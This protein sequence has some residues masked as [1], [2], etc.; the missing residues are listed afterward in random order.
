MAPGRKQCFNLEGSPIRMPT[1]N[2]MP[3][4]SGGELAI[5]LSGGGARAAYQVGLLRC[6]A[7]HWPD[8]R[9]P[10]ITGVSAGAINAGYLA[11]CTEGFTQKVDG[12]SELWCSLTMEQVFRTDSFSLIGNGLRL[13]SMLLSGGAVTRQRPHS[14]VDTAP[15]RS[16]LERALNSEKGRLPGI[17]K[18]L[19]RGDLKAVAITTSSYSTGQ[20]IT[21][22]QGRGIALWDRAHRRAALRNLEVSHIM[23]SAAMPIFFPAIQIE[24]CWYGDGGIRLT[25]P[26]SPAVH[27]G[28]NRIL[29]ISTRYGRSNEEANRPSFSGYPPSAQVIGTLYNAVFL[30]LF[31]A[32]ALHMQRLN[33]L[34]EILPEGRSRLLRQV[35]LLALHPSRDV[36]ELANEYEAALPGAFRFLMRG[37]G[38][39]E[40]RSNDALSLLLFHPAYCSR[41][42]ELGE[43]DAEAQLDD[44]RE[45]LESE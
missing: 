16:L 43:A 23:A 9:V 38:T 8:L 37:L 21:W 33:K 28:A 41:L 20:S 18:N 3:G 17:V 40:T 19:K 44:I 24:E 7:R 35:K 42:I 39:R 10:I 1:M 29:A 25:A 6:L 13:G 2:S 31:E 26:L 5:V 4:N 15:L 30:D 27:M 32:D 22:V 34:I 45:L 36:G 14:L 11:A 12:L